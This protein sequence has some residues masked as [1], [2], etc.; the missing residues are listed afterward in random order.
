MSESLPRTAKLVVELERQDSVE[1]RAIRRG[2]D[3]QGSL[4]GRGRRALSSR[5]GAVSSPRYRSTVLREIPSRA[6]PTALRP[7]P[8]DARRVDS[9]VREV[10]G[11]INA[12]PPGA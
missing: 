11:I 4:A 1:P 5:L 9:L 6:L 2:S 8:C 7:T 10:R 12:F 3:Y